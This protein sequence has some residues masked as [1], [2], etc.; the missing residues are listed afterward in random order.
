VLPAEAGWAALVRFEAPGRHALDEEALV[1]HLLEREGVLVQPGYVFEL[2]P[3][4]LEVP[5]GH[6]V[7]GL[8]LEPERFAGGAG[9]LARG[10]GEALR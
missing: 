7:V 6:L 2:E 5:S 3:P 10:L 4:G 1:L 9:A 8:L